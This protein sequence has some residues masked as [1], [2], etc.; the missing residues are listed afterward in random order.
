MQQA[1]IVNPAREVPGRLI[2]GLVATHDMKDK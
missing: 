1:Q 2:L